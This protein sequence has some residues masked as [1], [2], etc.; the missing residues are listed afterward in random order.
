MEYVFD[1]YEM[2]M[3][4][5]QNNSEILNNYC[6]TIEQYSYNIINGIYHY[7]A[8]NNKLLDFCN[9]INVNIFEKMNDNMLI[10]LNPIITK[11]LVQI[12]KN[13][14]QTVFNIY[15]YI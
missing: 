12:G 1:H 9:I 8:K 11:L 15:I 2:L 5:L 7:C 4:N 14:Q 10:Y 13:K 3:N 6:N